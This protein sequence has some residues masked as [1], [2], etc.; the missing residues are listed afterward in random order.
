[1]RKAEKEEEAKN[2]ASLAEKLFVAGSKFIVGQ[3]ELS[4]NAKALNTAATHLLSL[5]GE[6]GVFLSSVDKD[7]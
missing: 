2:A 5:I 1:M 7:R 4:D 6:G 3:L